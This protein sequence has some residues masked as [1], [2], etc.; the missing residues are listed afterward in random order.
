MGGIDSCAGL[1]GNFSSVDICCFCIG[2]EAFES[3][4]KIKKSSKVKNIFANIFNKFN[5][6]L[7][8][9]GAIPIVAK[10][11]RIILCSFQSYHII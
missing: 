10:V 5:C 1:L 8:I 2:L 7:L 3:G 11:S 4:Q 6:A 9:V